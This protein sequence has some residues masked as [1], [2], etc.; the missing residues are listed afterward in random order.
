M[1]NET[2]IKRRELGRLVS[3]NLFSNFYFLISNT[4]LFILLF[5]VQGHTQSINE[6]LTEA[7]ENN[8]GLKS[9]YFEFEAAISTLSYL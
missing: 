8:P 6:Y 7:A 9:S 3:G 4:L 2:A 1:E 5:A